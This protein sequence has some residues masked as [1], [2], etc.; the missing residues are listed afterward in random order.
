MHSDLHDVMGIASLS[1][2][3]YLRPFFLI[4]NILVHFLLILRIEIKIEMDLCTSI[5]FV[6]SNKHIILNEEF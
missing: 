3:V 5:S 2:R 4:L 6:F 1:L